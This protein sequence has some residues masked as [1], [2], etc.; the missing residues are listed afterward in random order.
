[1][2]TQKKRAAGDERARQSGGVRSVERAGRILEALLSAAPQGLRL[3][4]IAELTELHK[5]TALRLLRT[6]CDIGVIRR[7][8]DADRYRWD[9]LHW[10]AV[11][12]KL[13]GLLTDADSLQGLLDELATQSGETVGIAYPDVTRRQILFVATSLSRN[14]LRFDPGKML[15]W[16]IHASAAGKVC[17]A[18]GRSEELESLRHAPLEAT[19]PGTVTSF[20]KLLE[21]VEETRSRG[22]GLSREEGYAGTFGV[23]VPIFDDEGKV[24][25]ALQ[26][27][28]PIQRGTDA[29]VERWLHLLRRASEDATRLLYLASTVERRDLPSDARRAEAGPRVSAPPEGGKK[30]RVV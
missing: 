20:E 6:L 9:A 4:E 24:A 2:R 26:L 25:A 17:L 16:P 5:S 14:P 21:E 30:Y 11:A 1:M 15:T 19:A 22:Y 12:V 23:A 27:A 7:T 29:N 13:R 8:A 28:A 3:G 18:H 10:L